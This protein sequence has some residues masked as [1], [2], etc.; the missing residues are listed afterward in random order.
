[1]F[2]EFI[3]SK[4]RASK[5]FT[6]IE[7]LIVVAIIGLLATLVSISLIGAKARARDNK[8]IS[9][10]LAIQQAVELYIAKTGA[11][12]P[13]SSVANY[14]C[15]SKTSRTGKELISGG[16]LDTFPEEP[17]LGPNANGCTP[18]NPFGY[19]YYYYTLDSGPEPI[20]PGKKVYVIGAAMEKQ[21]GHEFLKHVPGTDK[22]YWVGGV[23]GLQSG[24]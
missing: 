4:R 1:M 12:P 2:K 3:L 10:I 14:E 21:A 13:S 5:G 6:L 20:E 9:D 23:V 7:L 15:L 8:R 18:N 19:R 24:T 11:P 22:M 16:Y 17:R